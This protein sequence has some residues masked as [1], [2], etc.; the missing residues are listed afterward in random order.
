MT[1]EILIKATIVDFDSNPDGSAIRVNVMGYQNKKIADFWIHR[2]DRPT[3][4]EEK[5]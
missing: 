3:V 4:V 2:L 5:P 1:D